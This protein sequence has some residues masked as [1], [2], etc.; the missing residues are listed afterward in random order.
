LQANITNSWSIY[1]RHELADIVHKQTVK[2]VGVLALES[3]QVQVLVN[4]SLAALDHLHGAQALGLKALHGMR[5]EAGEVLG[6]TLLGS[7]GKT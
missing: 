4:G 2:Q 1:E 3:G 5:Q 6:D 7:K